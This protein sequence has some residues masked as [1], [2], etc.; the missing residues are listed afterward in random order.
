MANKN[1]IDKILENLSNRGICFVSEKHLQVEFAI[2][3]T[4]VFEKCDIYP[5]YVFPDEKNKHIDLIISLANDKMIAIEFKYIVCEFKGRIHNRDIELRHQSA[6]PVRRYN[7]MMDISR[8]EYLKQKGKITVG[9]FVLISNEKKLWTESTKETIDED[10]KL[11][12]KIIKK[13]LKNWRKDAGSGTIKGHNKSIKINNNYK[14]IFK[15]FKE[16]K[17]VGNCLFKQLVI[18]I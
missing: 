8:L 14:L 9:Y 13:G 16:Y 4:K 1:K 2:E 6:L 7:C 12:N 11:S 18:E 17:G 3:A 5:E 10:F 15:N